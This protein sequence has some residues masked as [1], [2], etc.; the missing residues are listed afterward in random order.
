MSGS[1]G[2][3]TIHQPQFN[4]YLGV[5]AKYLLAGTIIHLD[6]VQF[7][8]NEY[9]NRNLICASGKPLWLTVPVRHNHGQSI[10]ETKVQSDTRW[11][12]KHLKT[13]R[14]FYSKETHFGEVFSSLAEV[15]EESPENLSDWN[16]RFLGWL[17]ERLGIEKPVV[18][19]SEM[20]DIPEG[21][22]ERLIELVRKAG[23][24]IYLSGANGLKYLDREKWDHQRVTVS[25]LRFTHPTYDQG[26][27]PFLPYCGIL[28]LLFREPADRCREIILSGVEVLDWD[29]EHAVSGA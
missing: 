21:R 15:Y 8:K 22:D 26:G 27:G 19:A 5:V 18:W 6:T 11:Q 13:L 20:A 16:G 28:D 1:P 17:F 23:G 4:P 29:G 3:V 12:D 2:P 9:Q 7:V 10:R 24:E 14:Q 25:F